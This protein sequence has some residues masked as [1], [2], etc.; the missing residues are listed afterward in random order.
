MFYILLQTLHSVC[1]IGEVLLHLQQVGNVQYIGWKLQVPCS[2]NAAIVGVLQEQAKVMEEELEKWK[3][4]VKETRGEYYEL[5][6]YTTLQL[7]TLREKLGTIKNSE[8]CV[9][10]TPDV[11]ALLQSISSKVSAQSV[12]DAVSRAVNILPDKGEEISQNSGRD[13]TFF[14]SVPCENRAQPTTT[15]ASPPSAL[16]NPLDS[17]KPNLVEGD[18]SDEQ[19]AIMAQIISRLYCSKYLVLRAFEVCSQEQNDQYDFYEWCENH[20][21]LDH[22]D[23]DEADTYEEESC[24]SDAGR[25]LSDEDFCYSSGMAL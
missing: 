16:G 12:T 1:H 8:T 15:L 14:E 19:R 3:E 5:N 9:E 25:E 2:S 10:V 13:T 4:I 6:H 20:L 24:Q 18:L 23:D 17:I 7:L 11:L 22:F 21:H